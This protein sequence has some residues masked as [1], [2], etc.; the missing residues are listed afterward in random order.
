LKQRESFQG[1]VGGWLI[2][3]A[4]LTS[5]AAILFFYPRVPS[6][7]EAQVPRQRTARSQPKTGTARSRP[8][9]SS[10]S[11]KHEDHRLPKT[12][13][14][15]SDCHTVLSLEA[16][17]V[18]AAATKATIKAYP[19]HDKCLDCHRGTPPQ[20]F[21]G[22]TPVICA[23]CHTNSSPRLTKNDMSPFPKQ[24]E[25]M[26]LGDLSLKFNHD[27]TSHRRECT[28]CHINIAQ[29]DIVKADSPI[30]N[31]ASSAC[32]RKPNVK[33]GFDQE[34]LLLE[35]DDITGQKNRHACVGCHSTSIGGTP[36]PC[37][38]YKLF[39]GDHTYF[40]STDFPKGAKLITERCK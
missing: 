25:Q 27:S 18:V 30:S 6:V 17:N 13:L 31:C 5:I 8:N 2:A 19:Y 37:T 29:L 40:N 35:D 21:R 24:S 32:H 4:L 39:D 33:P 10:A 7:V 22:T 20:L 3:L 9:P 38:H 36:A 28:T 11:F 15:C 14:N 12:K 16:S 23:V 34:M 1:K 26:I